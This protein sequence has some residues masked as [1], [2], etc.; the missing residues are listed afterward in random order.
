[1]QTEQSEEANEVENPSEESN[2]E[3]NDLHLPEETM[4]DS[5]E[6]FCIA[7]GEGQTPLPIFMDKNCIQLAF[8]TI[9]FGHPRGVPPPGI[10]LSLEDYI[11]SEIRRYDRRCCRNDYLLCQHKIAQV[12]QMMKQANI[13]MRKSAQTN[14]ITASQ[15]MNKEFIDN[16]VNSDNAYRFLASIIGS[17]PYWE[18]QKKRA[19]AMVRQLG[20]FH[21]FITLTAAETHWNELLV[22]LKKTVDKVDITE[23]D[24]SKMEFE[25]K[26]RLISEDPVTC[27]QYFNHRVRELFKTWKTKNGPFRNY[28]I[29]HRYFR[30]E[31]QHR[32]S[33][34]VHLVL[35]IEDAPIFNPDDQESQRT[36]I[37]FV[38]SIITTDSEDPEVQD[39]IKYQYHK[40][41]KTCRKRKRGK[42][43]CRFNAPFH[44][45]EETTVL[46]PFP[47]GY[48]PSDQMQEKI[49]KINEKIP[50]ILDNKDEPVNSF[51][52]FLT[53]LECTKE[54]YF[55]AIRSKLSHRKIFLKRKPKDARINGYNK[56]ILTL[57][58]SN[59]DIQYVLDVY[60]CLTYIV[61]YINKADRGVSRLLRQCVED[62]SRGHNVLRTKLKAVT[63]IV[64]N[65]SEVSAQ[66]ASWIRCRLPMSESTVVVEFINPSPSK[67]IMAFTFYIR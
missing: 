51:D 41:T 5:T 58:R 36:V 64:Y 10:R 29:L 52:D 25:E 11:N 38:D 44:P 2:E 34:H 9:W 61:D 6:G 39:V 59:M 67:V 55:E 62:F 48:K 3:F 31:F 12:L 49:K 53:K 22:I 30:I 15:V 47:T 16:A 24:A 13:V 46:E 23:E 40:C 56:K 65:S 20:G 57:M 26:A 33:P 7:P 60:S 54:E 4:L 35:W 42:E 43:S 66:E 45:M 37:E 8:P 63:N 18:N 19:L 17:P 50:T 1:M 14:N 32:G 28:K 27:S 21:L